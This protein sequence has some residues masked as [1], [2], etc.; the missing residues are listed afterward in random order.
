LAD[1]TQVFRRPRA[2]FQRLAFVII[3]AC[4]AWAI[5]L[6]PFAMASNTYYVNSIAGNDQADGRQPQSAWRSLAPVNA[7]TLE[8]GDSVLLAANSVFDGS[9]EIKSQ[10]APDRPIT[11][12]MYGDGDMPRID[13]HGRVQS[14][15]H[16]SNTQH[17]TVQDLRLT[18]YGETREAA[19]CGVQVDLK[20]F[21]IARGIM[22]RRLHISDV[23]GLLSKK[24]GGGS[25]IL[26]QNEGAATPSAYDGLRI[27]ENYIER[28]ERNGINFKS[29]FAGRT[30][31]FPSRNVVIRNNLLQEIPGDGI[32]P[33]G[34][35]GTLIEGNVIRLGTPLLR[36]KEHSAAAGIWP[37]SCDNTLI[38][39]NE[40]S[41]HRA[42]QDGQGFDADWNCRGT[43][44][45]YNYSHHNEGGFL[46]ICNDGNSKPGWNAG[47]TG[48]IVRHN[49]S[50]NDGLREVDEKTPGGRRATAINLNGPFGGAQITDNLIIVP[51]KLTDRV[52]K[53]L[54]AVTP[55]AGTCE[56]IEIRRNTFLTEGPAGF[57]LQKGKNIVVSGNRFFGPVTHPD[58]QA[59]RLEQSPV[60][61][62][63]AF[64]G[65]GV[66]SAL[67]LLDSIPK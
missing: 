37:W 26:V 41:G 18:N 19:R 54:V 45:Q 2:A 47:N 30:N 49:V 31:W 42:D 10:G 67:R 43:I 48:V 6:S 51:R 28:T 22:L 11:F 61:D 66:R 27:E 40:V 57:E 14:A 55:W 44:I 12:G 9:L 52:D 23:N 34:C 50:Y 35:D 62:P 58:A 38:Q 17:V 63:F 16:L 21:G 60:A 65:F 24:A 64:P 7:L 20:D 46:L 39:Y 13:G 29:T 8:P 33:V 36:W 1:S 3:P 15:V 5:N 59:I 4:F 56:D 25:A 32:V 53:Q